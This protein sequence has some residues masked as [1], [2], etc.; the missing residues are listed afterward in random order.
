MAS[1]YAK[2]TA[3]V[4]GV[5]R[6]MYCSCASNK[7]D[8][9]GLPIPYNYPLLEKFCKDT[10]WMNKALAASGIL[11]DGN[12]VTA[13]EVK[14]FGP[15]VGF[16]SELA[17]L[18]VTYKKDDEAVI[19]DVIVKFLPHGL[20][21]R[22]VMDLMSLQKYEAFCYNFLLSR[23]EQYG[24]EKC[25]VP[26]P[27]PLFVDFCSGT[28]MSVLMLEKITGTIGNQRLPEPSMEQAKMM[29][30]GI[31]KIHAYFWPVKG[32]GFPHPES[33]K[34]PTGTSP[35]YKIVSVKIRLLFK[36]V[37]KLVKDVNGYEMDPALSKRLRGNLPSAFM[38]MLFWFEKS[39]FLTICHGD[40]RL[41][42]WYFVDNEDGSSAGGLY[43]WA[44]ALRSPCY[45]DLSWMMT[46]SWPTGFTRDNTEDLLSL[47]WTT[48]KENL[49][50]DCPAA[51]SLLFGDFRIGY[52]LSLLVAFAKCVIAYE[53]LTKM[54]K[55]SQEYKEKLRINMNGTNCCLEQIVQLNALDILDDFIAGN[56]KHSCAI[57]RRRTVVE[58]SSSAEILL[59]DGSLNGSDTVG[60]A[61]NP[62]GTSAS[63]SAKVHP[64]S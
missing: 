33:M 37:M 44:L 36:G 47:Y 62:G 31:A 32:K 3:S 22:L 6:K 54:N 16:Y 24:M 11:R 29:M 50:K 17:N 18:K 26:V 38:K 14:P 61:G 51:N 63:G 64:D 15:S 2:L 4:I 42:N 7:G 25:P 27:R 45:Y 53:S 46:H 60:T 40:S 58:G 41:D 57:N 19:K 49:P 10:V 20:E 12:E 13:A 8:Y 52:A 39:P 9:N 30:I 43:D 55:E 1:D 21:K 35:T 34:L 56:L 23:W 5:L 59:S 48:L 28:N